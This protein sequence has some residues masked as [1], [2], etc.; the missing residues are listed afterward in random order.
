MSDKTKRL[1]SLKKKGVNNLN[2]GKNFTGQNSPLYCKSRS[3]EDKDKFGKISKLIATQIRE[4]YKT[5]KF[6]QKELALKYSLSSQHVY[7]IIHNKVWK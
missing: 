5:G 7:R 3:D 1:M 6:L 4:E 2:Y